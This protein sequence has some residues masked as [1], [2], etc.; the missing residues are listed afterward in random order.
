MPN[1]NNTRRLIAIFRNSMKEYTQQKV[2]DLMES[3]IL[4]PLDYADDGSVLWFDLQDNIF[5][6]GYSG[7]NIFPTPDL[8]IRSLNFIRETEL[9][10]F[11]EVLS[12]Q[13]LDDP[14]SIDNIFRN[15]ANYL[16][17]YEIN[18]MFR[19]WV[20]DCFT[21][22]VVNEDDNNN[23]NNIEIILESQ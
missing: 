7:R 3:N 17:E 18:Y 21:E 4:D 11:G 22:S 8:I 14:Y 9:L 16:V 20:K 19:Q 15:V 6:E 13:D 2:I 12:Y 1:N 5:D 23:N 10:N